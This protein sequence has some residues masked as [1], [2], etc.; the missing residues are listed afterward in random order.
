MNALALAKAKQA[1]LYNHHISS[2]FNR[3][4][5]ATESVSIEIVGDSTANGDTEWFYKTMEWLAGLFSA[6]TVYQRLWNNTTQLFDT[7]HTP[8]Q[9]GSA[10]L[11]YAEIAAAGT[12]KMYIVNTTALQ[13]T[14]DL[15]LRI[16]CA[17]DDYINGAEQSLLSKLGGA[18]TRSW[19]WYIS[20]TG[21]PTFYFSV[22]GTDLITK[23]STA[24]LSTTNGDEV[25]LK[26]TLD[27]DNGAGG[28]DIAFYTSTDG[29]TWTQL[30]TT[31]TTAGTITLNANTS[32]IEIS[33]RGAATR[34]AGKFY[35]TEIRNGI[36]GTLVA[37]P[38]F[39]MSFPV[40]DDTLSTSFKDVEG[41][42]IVRYGGTGLTWG[43]GSPSLLMLN[44]SYSGSK[45]SYSAD[46]TR[47][48]AQTTFE[49]QLFF[50][51]Y[52]HN[53]G[54][55]LNYINATVT[56]TAQ[57]GAATT[58]TLAASASALNDVYNNYT[59][60]I[61]SGTGVG[62][63]RI[64]ND[65]VGSTKVATVSVAWDTN[66]DATSVY[67]L[68]IYPGFCD[69][70]I[71]KYPNMGIICV[72]QNPDTSALTYYRQHNHR[73]QQIA[74]FAASR[75]YGL[76]DAYTAFM[77]TNDLSTY[78]DVDGEHPTTAGNNLWAT[79]AKKFLSASL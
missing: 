74:Q 18:G 36:D 41:N 68:E 12:D 64:I 11:G 47:F 33:S 39:G 71:A 77:D 32:D 76:V 60:Y 65:Y 30:G 55:T 16:H 42:T 19:Q 3:L 38:E 43:N 6:Y 22:N 21:K 57:A 69:R 53:E 9:V 5:R 66:P 49:P 31:V 75:S 34:A 61:T 59:V 35:S 1:K 54:T 79:T 2:F 58:I 27:V 25:Y 63:S 50:I 8:I 10:G 14:G 52:A 17:L 67:S 37:S 56:G 29:T 73:C 26:M 7:F 20:S 24:A 78:V 40:I 46:I 48:T 45:I 70:L 23:T 44:G 28:Y 72:A 4:R 13:I 51:N 15:D 62:Q